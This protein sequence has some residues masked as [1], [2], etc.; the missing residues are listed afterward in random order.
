M[1]LGRIHGYDS[2]GADLG[3]CNA[4]AIASAGKRLLLSTAPALSRSA[5]RYDYL[6]E[7]QDPTFRTVVQKEQSVD[8]EQQ[9]SRFVRVQLKLLKRG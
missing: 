3:C 7:N 1:A 9:S 2:D 4:F 8:V 5:V 6:H